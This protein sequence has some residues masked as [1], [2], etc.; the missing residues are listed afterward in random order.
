MEKK[1][2]WN[3]VGFIFLLGALFMGYFV[4]SN[5][6]K[7]FI[8]NDEAYYLVHFRDFN[9]IITV[10]A[11]NYFRIFQVF[12]TD[13]IYHFRLITYALLNVSSYLLF[14]LVG[15]YYKLKISPF[16]FGVLGLCMNFLTWPATIVALNQYHGNTILINISLSCMMLFLLYR[17]SLFILISG[18]ILGIFLFDGV[19]HTITIIPITAY[20]L[21]NFWKKDKKVIF[22]FGGGILLGILFYF[23]FIESFSTFVKQLEYIEIYKRFHR[24]QH[25]IRFYFYWAAQVIG[26]IVIPLTL[27]LYLINKY[28]VKTKKTNIL[29]YILLGAG[30]LIAL[31]SFYYQNLHIHYVFLGLLVYRFFLGD[32]SSEAKTFLLVLFFVPFGLAFGSGFYF[33][34][35]GGMYQIYFFLALNIILI[36]LYPLKSYLIYIITFSIYIIMYPSFIHDKGWKDFVYTEQTEKV[37]ING[38]DLY[39]DKKRKSEIEELRPYLQNQQNVIYSSNHLMGYLYILNAKPPIYYYFTLKAYIS[40][41]IEKEGKKPDDFIY[42]E[43][44]D[45]L[46]S[47]KEFIPLKFVSHPE[48]YKVVKT[49]KFTLYLPSDYQKK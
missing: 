16:L 39:L 29:D 31:T 10:D 32:S 40:F 13:N 25:P 1:L 30:I 41:I 7:G 9:K 36:K 19:P 33:H 46:F 26:F 21:Y 5:L 44:T 15:K 49:G 35:R 43:S 34:I 47:P 8:M 4:Y 3:A 42:L 45:Y 14:F 38:Y 12:Y 6:N 27:F 18:F 17:K 20:L 37:K 2:Y 28:L 24:K 23:S 11:T 22:L 48:K